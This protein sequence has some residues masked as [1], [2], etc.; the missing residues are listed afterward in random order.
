MKALR[1]TILTVVIAVLPL[2]ARPGIMWERLTDE[3]LI[4]KS[5][6]IVLAELAGQTRLMPSPDGPALWLGALRVEETLKGDSQ[7]TVRLL[8]LPSPEA[9]RSSSD[10]LYRDGQ[11][12]LWFLRARPPGGDGLYLADHPQ[13]FLAAAQ[14][15]RIVEMREKIQGAAPQ[16]P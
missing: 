2:L 6:V 4:E 15:E 3:K 8:L 12:G 7:Q 5:E 13:R 11:R 10:I 14:A 1:P 9:P 16:Q